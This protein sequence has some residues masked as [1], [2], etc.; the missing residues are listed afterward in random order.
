V[1]VGIF[2][3]GS[4]GDVQPYL[5]IAIGL[6]RAGHDVFF[7][8]PYDFA[9]LVTSYGVPFR[10]LSMSI[11]EVLNRPVNQ[12]LPLN[13]ITGLYRAWR[14]F[15]AL[16]D[17][18]NSD[19]WR[20][21][22]D[23]DAIIYTPLN[24]T[25]YGVARKL[26]IPSFMVYCLPLD[27]SRE[28]APVFA[29]ARRKRSPLFNRL[30]SELG[31]CVMWRVF[32]GGARRLRRQLSLPPLPFSGPLREYARLGHPIFYV[33]SPSVLPRPSDW[34]KDIHVVGFSFLGAPGQW[35]PPADLVEFLAAGLPPVFIGFGSMPHFN[36]AETTA[37]FVQAV[38]R[39]GQRAILQGGYAGL[40]AG[41]KLPNQ[42]FLAGDV[43]H[44]WL[45]PRVAAVMHHGGAGTTAA[46][47]RAGVPQI[48]VP[49]ILDQPFWAQ[50]AF[51]LGVSPKPFRASQLSVD[52]VTQALQAAAVDRSMRQRAQE[53]AVKVRA[54]DGVGQIV[55][56]FEQYMAR[57]RL[58][59]A[60]PAPCESSN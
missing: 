43:P 33:F 11:S 56:L 28:L 4:R 60:R 25:V 44:S 30:A 34:R 36:S 10:P 52:R 50:C 29:G 21:L 15:R 45:F 16:G 19:A 59:D 39:S 6:Q 8:A 31:Y 37:I 58:G 1:K 47:F 5:A 18:L 9:E 55:Q 40:G 54:E 48:V 49:H 42:I 32:A 3:F 24:P 26:D 35:Q 14:E 23:A 27:P 46:A 7:C 38:E 20:L 41:A 51:D 22:Q 2:T 17:K 53:I 12:Q 57:S 13:K